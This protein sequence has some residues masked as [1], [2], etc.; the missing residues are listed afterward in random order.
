M[1]HIFNFLSWSLQLYLLNIR[2]SVSSLLVKKRKY[3]SLL[4][5]LRSIHCFAIF[6]VNICLCS[7]GDLCQNVQCNV[8][9]NCILLRHIAYQ[10]KIK[11]LLKVLHIFI[12]FLILNKIN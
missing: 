10:G 7:L 2:C 8:L 3:D 5:V 11:I 4:F 6:V 1:G 12:H 9:F